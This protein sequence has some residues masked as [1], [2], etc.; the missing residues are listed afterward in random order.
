MTVPRIEVDQLHVLREL[1]AGGQGRVFAVAVGRPDAPPVAYK[2]YLPHVLPAVDGAALTTL[3][4]FFHGLD[5]VTRTWL[6]ERTAWPTALVT[7]AGAICGFLM[8]L[9]PPECYANLRLPA[10]YT[11]QLLG[12]EYLLNPIEYMAVLEIGVSDRDRLLLLRDLVSTLAR[13]HSLGV[14]AGDLSA[15]AVVVGLYPHQRCFLV[16]CDAVLLRG[17]SVLPQAEAPDWA[18]PPGEPVPTV[19]SDAY[20]VGLLATRLLVGDRTTRDVSLLPAAFPEI[21]GLVLRCL[22]V[23]GTPESRPTPVEWVAALDRA[24]PYASTD[25]PVH[26]APPPG[27]FAPAGPAPV[28]GAP[29][30]PPVPAR[31]GRGW[32]WIPVLAVVLVLAVI[33]GVAGYSRLIRTGGNSAGPTAGPTATVRPTVTASPVQPTPSPTVS[34]TPSPVPTVGVVD[35]SAVAADP[36]AADVA[37]MFDTYFS[38]IN[39]HNYDAALAVYDPAGAINPG[40]PAQRNAFT[41]DVSTSQDSE[42]RVLSLGPGTAPVAV[43]AQVTFR[44]MQAQGYGPASNPNETC[45]VWTISYSLTE[46]AP[47]RYRILRGSGQHQTC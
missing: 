13:L 19:H 23:T 46:P 30:P 2:E 22:T 27:G 16:G 20:K 31:G 34:P 4:E 38:S 12:L 3:V 29:S 18:V 7:R 6:G 33:A 32:V 39:T 42:I 37:R 5:G 1:G 8:R 21:A 44:S 40:D 25:A 28:P 35:Y 45:T 11:S 26:R 14:V 41:H 36:R 24:V 15:K 9:A 47:G 17:V 10:G 43:V